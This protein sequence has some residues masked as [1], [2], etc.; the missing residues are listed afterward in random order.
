MSDVV[1]INPKDDN[2]LLLTQPLFK[3]N[4]VDYM[5]DQIDIYKDM[6]NK[7]IK[8]YKVYIKPHP[9]D[10][11]DYKKINKD[12]KIINKNMPIEVLKFNSNIKFKKAVTIVS[13]SIKSLNFVEEK[14]EYGFEYLD[15]YK[16]SK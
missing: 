3:D 14:I 1:K 7:Y 5:Q 4:M 12:V 13:S 8:D 2:V 16:R 10:D 15:K 6:I 9:R 11:F